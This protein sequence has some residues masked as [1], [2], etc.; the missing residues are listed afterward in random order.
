MSGLSLV[1]T[2]LLYF[3]FAARVSHIRSFVAPL[4]WSGSVGRLF[5]CAALGY[6]D[7][8]QLLYFKLASLKKRYSDKVILQMLRWMP[9]PK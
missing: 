7:S 1:Q 9:E 5:G 4:R 8:L 6:L 3:A 2:F